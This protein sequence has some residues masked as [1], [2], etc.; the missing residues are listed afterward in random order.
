MYFLFVNGWK[1]VLED[2]ASC[3]HRCEELAVKSDCNEVCDK[4]ELLCEEG[5]RKTRESQ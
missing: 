3:K 2:K 1:Q 4:F 5:Q